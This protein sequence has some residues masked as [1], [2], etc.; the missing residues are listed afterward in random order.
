MWFP[1]L[2][3]ASLVKLILFFFFS[4]SMYSTLKLIP[5]E[6]HV[7][8]AWLCWLMLIPFVGYIFAW[9][10]LPFGIPK[11]LAQETGKCSKSTCHVNDIF[12]LGLAY[13]I[14]EFF[15]YAPFPPTSFLLSII[16]FIILI[17]YW[18]KVI[19]FRKRYLTN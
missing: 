13:L 10:M 15:V 16:G 9:I 14:I 2:V 5:E 1:T 3:T 11:T 18:R 17:I 12:A 19:K 4:L 8:P 7:V 6:K